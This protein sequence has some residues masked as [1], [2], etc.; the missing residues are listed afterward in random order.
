MQ[1]A[2]FNSESHAQVNVRTNPQELHKCAHQK[3]QGHKSILKQIIVGFL[4]CMHIFNMMQQRCT[5]LSE[6]HIH[7]VHPW[8]TLFLLLRCVYTKLPQKCGPLFN[9]D[10]FLCCQGCH[11]SVKLTVNQTRMIFFNQIYNGMHVSGFNCVCMHT[12][13]SWSLLYSLCW[14][15]WWFHMLWYSLGSMHLLKTQV[16][17]ML[18]QVTWSSVWGSEGSLQRSSESPVRIEG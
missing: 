11:N 5:I 17:Q 2:D 1:G 8:L 13:T 16:E 15:P 18:R 10:I 14:L 7:K 9:Q 6:V 4:L 3:C 12:C